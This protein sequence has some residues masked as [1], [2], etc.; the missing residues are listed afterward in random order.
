MIVAT[1]LSR[2]PLS[3][4]AAQNIKATDNQ[5]MNAAAAVVATKNHFIPQSQPPP[6]M[7]FSFSSSH[8]KSIMDISSGNAE[9]HQ[10]HHMNYMRTLKESNKYF[11]DVNYR[12]YCKNIQDIHNNS[13]KV[14]G[15]TTSN[16]NEHQHDY[17][18]AIQSQSVIQS[19]D[20]STSDLTDL[21]PT[22]MSNNIGISKNIHHN[23]T[24]N[25]N[26]NNIITNETDYHH[27]QNHQNNHN[28]G[29]TQSNTNSTPLSNPS[30]LGGGNDSAEKSI[31]ANYDTYMKNFDTIRARQL[32]EMQNNCDMNNH[33]DLTTGSNNNKLGNNDEC[34]SGDIR[35]Y[36]SSDD[37][38]QTMSSERDDKMGSG[39][40]DEGKFF[41]EVHN[42]T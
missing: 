4:Q 17:D 8:L 41:F 38:N 6:D 19:N 5:F 11:M 25:D 7:N 22:T 31:K 35:N 36:A 21:S 39:S 20:D 3:H 27:L 16:N 30:S 37:L 1:D 42:I 9:S 12:N 32:D 29:Q 23:I 24:S 14:F 18:D 34:S 13:M 28:H 15:V 26:G 10:E 2:A 33:H 40:D